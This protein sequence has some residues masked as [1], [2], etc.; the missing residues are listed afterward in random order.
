MR[1]AFI[2]RRGGSKLEING[3]IEKDFLLGSDVESGDAVITI[4]ETLA[5]QYCLLSDVGL[6]IRGRNGQPS[7]L[8][9]G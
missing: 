6:G 2:T 4:P 8:E 5:W 7:P 9:R 1:Q 3:T